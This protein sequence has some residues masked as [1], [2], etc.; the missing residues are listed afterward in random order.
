MEKGVQKVKELEYPF[1]SEYLIKKK[2]NIKKSLLSRDRTYLEK[3]IAILG[4]ST[5]ED[6]KNLLDL[7][8][9]NDGIKA[10]FYESE[11]NQFWQDAMFPPKELIQFHPDILYIHTSNR[12]ISTFP[13]ITESE[14]EIERKLQE[15]YQKFET[16][17]EHLEETYH[18]PIIQ[19]NMELPYFRILGNRDSSD[20]HGRTNFISRLNE[21]F[22]EFA[23]KHSNFY[24]NDIHY[25]SACYG[26]DKWSD[27]FYW[28]MYKYAL[29]VPAI[30]E[31]A[32]QLSHIIKAIYGKNK[33]ALVLDLDNTL[34][35]GVVGDDGVENLQIGQET[36]IGQAYLEWQDYI[37]Q[38]KEMGVLLNISSKNE[39][40][41]AIAG[42]HHP[43][44]LLKPDD[45]ILI[46]ANW[47][48]KSKNIADIANE[49]N[50]GVDSL[51]FLDDNPAERELIR[52]QLPS[53]A[54]PELSS[55]E[56][57]IK[58]T[59]RHGYFEVT[60][61]SAD[62]LE[63]NKMYKANSERKKA[64]RSFGDYR[65]Y[66]L[67]LEMVAV[68]RSFEK[69]YFS[70]I[71]QLTNKS[72]QFNLTTRRYSQSEI[73]QIAKDENYITLY[74]KLEDKFGDNGVVT[75]IIGKQEKAVCYLELWLMSC[76][77][78]KREM[79][80][81]MMDCLIEKC[82][83][84]GIC[85]I[86]GKFY[87]TAK[88]GMV[89]EFYGEMGFEKVSEDEN[90]NTVWKLNITEQYRKKNTVIR[91]ETVQDDRIIAKGK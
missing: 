30:P 41:N 54:V 13:K 61:L 68:I 3:K 2:K 36:P 59:D 46:K 9:L 22:N 6:V 87:P 62:D 73:E 38:Q 67:S 14:A 28:H 82:R 85:Q 29:C 69:I 63:R 71:A 7:F 23:R 44:S 33:K 25:L 64:E 32:Y 84:R 40:E 78:L 39:E 21:K 10:E 4:G 80:Y 66:L 35:G 56:A 91:V 45:F 57:Y 75:V 72:N 70:R 47:E 26:L 11:Y 1:D 65:D 24:I 15:V 52:Q 53:V 81:A 83:D 5:T 19:N 74:G 34:W 37:R 17:W 31:L 20:F 79:E 43:D 55:V 18:C 90:A 48:T 86:I 49:L 42:L 27:P 16:M 88:N 50:I 8:L 77:V 89:K 12:N 76:R 51:V 60:S 58:E